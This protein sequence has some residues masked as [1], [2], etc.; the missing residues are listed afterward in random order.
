MTAS[1]NEQYS[2]FIKDTASSLGF[3]QCGIAEAT[4]LSEDAK[5]L[6]AWL[7]KGYH[8]SMA[9]MANHFDMR[10]DPRK[11]VPDAKSVI[12]L[13]YNYFPEKEQ[14]TDGPKI[15]KYAY[16]TDY[17]VVIKAKL[18]ELLARM[19]AR[20]G[21]INGRGFVDSA[22]VLERT[23][24]QKSGLGWVGKNGNLLSKHHGSFFF[25]A[26]LVVDIALAYDLAMPTDHC[27]TCTACIDAC[28]TQ[29][30]LPNKVI[31]GE[32]CI[33]H[34]TIELKEALIP[35]EQA[36]KFSNWMFGCDTCQDVCPWNRFSKPHTEQLFEI[37]PQ[38]LNFN[39]QTWQAM[40]EDEFNKAFKH[41]PLRRTKWRG[42]QR[43]L[44]AL[45][46]NNF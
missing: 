8:G 19:Q 6:E 2:S 25:I 30:I 12:T 9:Y 41:S 33:S 15:S 11:L 24:A 21:S 16:G 32:Q 37:L 38:I 10:V 13:L 44:K 31:N 17:H 46:Q 4:Y 43:N 34:Y 23:W 40:S 39:T 42:I 20:I 22:P 5:R 26:T 14:A 18:N 27:G 36:A 28:P 29:A 7:N 45:A 3:L 1:T 35:E